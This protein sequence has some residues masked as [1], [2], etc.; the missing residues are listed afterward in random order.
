MSWG[1]EPPLT[2]SAGHRTVL[3]YIQVLG[4]AEGRREGECIQ[5]LGESGLKLFG[6]VLT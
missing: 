4:K 1:R 6:M 3:V 2:C 5:L